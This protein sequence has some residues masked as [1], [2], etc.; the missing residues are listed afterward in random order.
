MRVST[1]LVVTLF[2]LCVAS[3]VVL[4]TPQCLTSLRSLHAL[5]GSLP[6]ALISCQCPKSC[7]TT[8]SRGVPLTLAP[9]PGTVFLDQRV[10]C[11]ITVK[12]RSNFGQSRSFIHCSLGERLEWDSEALEVAG[13]WDSRG[14][15][16]LG[17]VSVL[18]FLHMFCIVHCIR[19]QAIVSSL[20]HFF[21]LTLSLF[22]SFLVFFHTL[23]FIYALGVVIQVI[24]H[25]ARQVR[26][27]KT[28][29]M[30]IST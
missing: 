29:L 25:H 27:H 7:V 15:Y 13:E 22:I 23:V 9:L 21:R 4:Q 3:I 19:T 10:Y 18:F 26:D 8:S 2:K 12:G 20:E 17:K 30:T 28:R 14:P 1:G 24:T 11:L 16:R 5:I 6:M